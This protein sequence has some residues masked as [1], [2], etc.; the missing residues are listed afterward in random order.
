[1]KEAFRSHYIYTTLISKRSTCFGF[2]SPSI[3]D[4]ATDD[5]GCEM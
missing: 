1:M 3:S 2:D 5:P 4:V